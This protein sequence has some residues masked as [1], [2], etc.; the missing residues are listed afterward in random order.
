MLK[1]F[2]LLTSLFI[3]IVDIRRHR[4]PNQLTLL[5]AALLLFDSVSMEIKKVV[6]AIPI[7]LAVG[8]IGK[9]GAGDI[10][11]L[12][13]LL[14]T[15]GSL[16][17]NQGYFLGMAIISLLGILGSSLFSYF[18]SVERPKSIAFA[19]SILVPFAALY[20]AI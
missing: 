17:L 20:L 11:L 15:S 2:V 18:K 7:L 6:I 3:S 8:Y 14:I 1:L 12:L 9:V 16:L 4:I 10:K 19:P 5:L 13:A